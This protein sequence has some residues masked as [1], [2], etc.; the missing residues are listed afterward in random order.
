M[1]DWRKA[2]EFLVSSFA[3]GLFGQIGRAVLELWRGSK[4][5]APTSDLTYRLGTTLTVG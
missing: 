1:N 3:I 5:I 4:R 2:F